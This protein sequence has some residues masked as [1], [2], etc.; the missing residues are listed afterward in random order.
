M[1]AS[2]DN[3]CTDADSDVEL[4]GIDLEGV[5]EEPQG[6]GEEGDENEGNTTGSIEGLDDSEDEDEDEEK[7]LLSEEALE[8]EAARK[9][10]LELL[11]AEQKKEHAP[12]V[13]AQSKL[14]YLL[15]QSDVFAH[16]LAGK[17]NYFTI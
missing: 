3:N 1:G 14:D 9:E 6:S 7:K 8:L 10:R 12:V 16:F 17:F 5:S 13:D 15:Q 4:D 2:K 11:E